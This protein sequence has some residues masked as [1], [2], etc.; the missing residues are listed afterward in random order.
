VY[1]DSVSTWVAQVVE[2][3]RRALERLSPRARAGFMRGL[4][5]PSE[6]SASF[7][8]EAEDAVQV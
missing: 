4:R 7:A 5:I 1:E 3:M 6:E 8:A 2:P